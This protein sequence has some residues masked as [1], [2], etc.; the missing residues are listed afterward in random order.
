MIR[1][2]R[3]ILLIALALLGIANFVV[4][5]EVYYC[6]GENSLDGKTTGV[7]TI[8]REKQTLFLE[9]TYPDRKIG[10]KTA[11]IELPL[12]PGNNEYCSVCDW[13]LLIAEER[14]YRRQAV[15]FIKHIITFDEET[16][17]LK[18]Y[19]IYLNR[20]GMHSNPISEYQ[21]VKSK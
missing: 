5:D 18:Y 20:R 10:G 1:R 4:A 21:C 19:Y 13:Q 11:N 12:E 9:A 6:V 3:H 2:S 8:S 15:N 17:E 7:L 16:L 14:F